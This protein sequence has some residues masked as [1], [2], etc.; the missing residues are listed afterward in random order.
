MSLGKGAWHV[1]I[2]SS[3]CGVVV[4]SV[5]CIETC[6]VK[7]VHVVSFSLETGKWWHAKICSVVT[8]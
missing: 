6:V 2:C 8:A 3:G 5:A 4:C 1:E 7:V